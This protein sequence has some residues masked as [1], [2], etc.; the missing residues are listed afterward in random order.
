MS[1]AREP[2]TP[3]PAC[4]PG[5]SHPIEITPFEGRVTMK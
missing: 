3:A 5:P 2:V 4:H 1:A